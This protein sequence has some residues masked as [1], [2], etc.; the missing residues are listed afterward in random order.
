MTAGCCGDAPRAV[1]PHSAGTA[2]ALCRSCAVP[3]RA[4]PSTRE[5]H[6][7]GHPRFAHRARRSARA[8][9]HHPQAARESL[10]QHAVERVRI[11]RCARPKDVRARLKSSASLEHHGSLVHSLRNRHRRQYTRTSTAGTSGAGRSCT[12]ARLWRPSAQS[13]RPMRLTPRPPAHAERRSASSAES[14]GRAGLGPC[15]TA[16]RG[17][18]TSGAGRGGRGRGPK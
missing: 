1:S 10:H 15:G 4:P 2:R 13:R 14:E 18:C 11:A 6:G 5:L 7:L 8:V 3:S 9:V 17:G 12:Q 16:S